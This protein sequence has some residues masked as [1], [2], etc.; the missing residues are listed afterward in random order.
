MGGR[1]KERWRE[2]K[3]E[4][5]LFKLQEQE[6]SQSLRNFR[7]LYEDTQSSNIGFYSSINRLRRLLNTLAQSVLD[8]SIIVQIIK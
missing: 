1:W 2:R 8:P 7:T 6:G 5:E 3:R 4:G